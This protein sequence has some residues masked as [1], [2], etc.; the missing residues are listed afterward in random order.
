MPDLRHALRAPIGGRRLQDV[1][2]MRHMLHMGHTEFGCGKRW[3]MGTGDE[4]GAIGRLGIG[5]GQ[6]KLV[7]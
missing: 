7:A 2:A 6:A 5:F 4:V 3:S 1:T